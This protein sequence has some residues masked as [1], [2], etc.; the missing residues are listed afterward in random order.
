MNKKIFLMAFFVTAM[1]V[2]PLSAENKP[3][4]DNSKSEKPEDS[5]TQNK[6]DSSS[7]RDSQPVDR[8]LADALIM[9]TLDR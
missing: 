9:S 4:N 3:D 7:S 1:F 2:L 6:E 5:S 8:D